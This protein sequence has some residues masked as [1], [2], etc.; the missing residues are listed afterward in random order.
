M[1]I[2]AKKVKNMSKSEISKPYIVEYPAH[3]EAK[4]FPFP[5]NFPLRDV[6]IGK[7][8]PFPAYRLDRKASGKYYLFEYVLK[9]EGKM[10]VG[11][12][13]QTVREGDLMFFDKSDDQ[14]YRADRADPFMKIWISFSSDYLGHMLEAYRVKTGV[15]RVDVKNVFENLFALSGSGGIFSDSFFVF[16]DGVHK[17]VTEIASSVYSE[18]PSLAVRLKNELSQCVYRK[19]DLDGI[20]RS[21][22]ISKTTLIRT[23]RRECGTT[24]YR[25]ILDEKLRA[26]RSLLRT[27]DMSVKE[28]AYLLC[29]TDEHYFSR[30]FAER[31][32]VS[33]KAYR[34]RREDGGRDRKK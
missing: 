20:S 4:S 12:K 19:A 13:W 16:A 3:E 11:G 26:A 25:F 24:P 32:S 17:I 31:Y 5:E 1:H 29:F 9:G 7:T 8:L 33:P 10:C 2:I 22:G 27:T 14:L 28:I 21:L 6:L 18:S 30:F 23:F 34:A 15:Y